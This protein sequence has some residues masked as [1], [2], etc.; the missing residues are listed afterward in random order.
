MSMAGPS[1]RVGA[2]AAPATDVPHLR[3]LAWIAL[4]VAVH[5]LILQHFWFNTPVWDDYGV[6][7]VVL[8]M[9]DAGSLRE[10]LAL[11]VGQHNEHRVALAR[12][13]EWVWTKALGQLDFRAMSLVGNLFLVGLLAFAWAQFRAQVAPIGF[14]AA[15]W[16]LFNWSY[17]EAALVSMATLSNIGVILAAFACLHFALRDG[18]ASALASVGTGIVAAFTQGNGLFALPLAAMACAFMAR[19]GRAVVMA[20]VAAA[21]WLAYFHGYSRP[22][23]LPSPLAALSRPVET[24]QLFLIVIGGLLPGRWSATLIGAAL[25]SALG[26]LLWRGLWRTHPA[27]ALWIAFILASAAAAA[28]ARVGLGVFHASRYAINASILAALVV[29]GYWALARPAGRRAQAIVVLAACASTLATAENWS[30]ASEASFLAR[31]LAKAVPATRD[32]VHDPYY[33]FRYPDTR[34]AREV[35]AWAERSGMYTPPVV[36]VHPFAVTTL[37]E[38]PGEARAIGGFDEVTLDGKRILVRGW[39]DIDAREPGNV[40]SVLSPGARPTALSAASWSRIDV[41]QAFRSERLLYSGFRLEVDFATADEAARAFPGLCVFARSPG[42][43]MLVPDPPV[44]ATRPPPECGPKGPA[45][46]PG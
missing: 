45:K 13:V 30:L 29:L 32:T 42:Q 7:G 21:L 4:P 22:P 1:D 8:R 39:T 10:W 17:F 11:L 18:W 26:W 23:H 40:L 5:L 14:A 28:A 2:A 20:V 46:V 12:L 44:S 6:V 37:A 19:R 36:T 16:L 31:L 34:Y 15:A 35:L 43:P 3:G 9:L 25:L 38:A 33:G 24:A 41:A 27:V